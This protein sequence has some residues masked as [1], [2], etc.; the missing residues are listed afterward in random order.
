[1]AWSL[2]IVIIPGV[3]LFFAAYLWG[4][5]RSVQHIVDQAPQSSTRQLKSWLLVALMS[6]LCL[7]LP[8]LMQRDPA[9]WL[10]FFILTSAYVGSAFK[11]VRALQIILGLLVL[12][13]LLGLLLHFIWTDIGRSM[14]VM[15][16][17]GVVVIGLVRAIVISHELRAAR[18]E[19]ARLAVM[20]ERLRIARDLHDLLGHNLSLITLK[21]ELAGRLL[22]VAPGRAAVEIQDIEQVARTT[23]QEVREAVSNYRQ[24]TLA[25]ELEGAQEILAAAGINYHYSGDKV[26]L[27]RLPST[28][29]TVLAWA[30]REGITNVIRH[31]QA[32]NCSLQLIREEQNILLEIL[33]DCGYDAPVVSP[34]TNSGHGLRGLAE[35]VETL[36][37]TFSAGL[38]SNGHFRL[39]ISVPTI[40]KT[41]GSITDPGH[42]SS[43]NDER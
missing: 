7:L 18:E 16:F 4:T 15:L 27:D 30:V 35:R 11:P 42:H 23:L 9:D 26:Y 19:I 12:D 43:N 31:G 20:N 24:P 17:V 37:G 10:D 25:S 6:G 36:G 2:L 1:M 39:S 13:A 8:T 3:T 5:W 34:N 21:S 38:E 29:E 14:I 32:R 22:M 28:S 33:N 40:Q 41:S